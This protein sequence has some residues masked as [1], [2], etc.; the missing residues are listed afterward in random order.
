M[1][2]SKFREVGWNDTA[3]K[4]LEHKEQ[5][6]QYFL[7]NKWTTADM[8]DSEWNWDNYKRICYGKMTDNMLSSTKGVRIYPILGGMYICHFDQDGV[9]TDPY[10]YCSADEFDIIE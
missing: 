3:N 4:A 8:T 6:I 7:D 10:I 5:M 1:F 9:V 2:T